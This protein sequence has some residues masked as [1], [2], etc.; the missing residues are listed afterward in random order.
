MSR[1]PYN[2]GNEDLLARTRIGNVAD[3]KVKITQ[4]IAAA[5]KGDFD[6]DSYGLWQ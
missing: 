6:G 5:I 3:D 2:Q 1:F 4:G